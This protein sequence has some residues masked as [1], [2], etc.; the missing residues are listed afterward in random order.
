MGNLRQNTIK[1]VKWS[2]VERFSVQGI[3]FLVGLVMARL[4]TPSDFGVVGML[5]IFLAV[6]QTF[7]DSGFSYA[8]IRKIDRTEIDCSTAF[9]FNVVIG[10]ACYAILYISAPYIASFY[11]TPILTDVTRVLALTIFLNSLTVVQIALLTIKIDFRTQAKV[12]LCG[13]FISGVLG[14]YLAFQGWGIWSLVYQHVCR[15]TI[16]VLL[17]W[18]QTKWRPLWKYSWSSFRDLFSFGSKLLLSGLL[19]TV[20]LNATNL[21]I[22]KF[23][24]SKDLG[25]YERGQ[26]F[27]K[28]PLETTSNIFQRVTFP[29]LSTIQDDNERLI[30]AYRNYIKFSSLILFFC[31]FLLVAM[32]KPLIIILLTEKWYDSILYLQLYCLANMLNHVTRINLNLLQVKGRSDL[33]LKLEIIKKSISLTMLVLSA[34]FGIIAICCSQIAY[35]WIAVYLNT[36]YTDKLFGFSLI[37]QIRDFFKYLLSSFIACLPVYLCVLMSVNNYVCLLA[38]PIVALCLYSFIIRK[39]SVFIE[40]RD[41]VFG[42]LKLKKFNNLID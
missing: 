9:Y 5:S 29:I 15:S 30:A 40:I 3:M 31:I 12:N 4:L 19:H 8:L 38:G 36:Y 13:A 14:I 26:Q 22:G 25:Y 17:F 20:Y 2:A 34:P 16:N 35:S 37:M 32:A 23:Y 18:I 28:I 39:D 21:V 27:G 7:I 1:G 42:Y 24:T 41:I 11:N 6:S 33:Y 10:L